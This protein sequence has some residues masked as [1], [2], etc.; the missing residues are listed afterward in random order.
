M[1]SGRTLLL[2]SIFSRFSVIGLLCTLAMLTEYHNLK[3][4]YNHPRLVELS[5]GKAMRVFYQAA[6]SFF[7]L[8]GDPAQEARRSGGA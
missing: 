7:A 2:F 5:S 3:I 6:D 4:A 8:F 1:K